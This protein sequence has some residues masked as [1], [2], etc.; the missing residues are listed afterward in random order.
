[1]DDETLQPF[2][3]KSSRRASHSKSSVP[4]KNTRQDMATLRPRRSFPEV[5]HMEF[6][7]PD[8]TTFST[9]MWCSLFNEL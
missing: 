9:A 3:D 5:S 7:N 4:K 6:N 8:G 1:M 2:V